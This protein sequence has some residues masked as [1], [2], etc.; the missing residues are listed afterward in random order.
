MAHEHI[1]QLYESRAVD[2]LST[3]V[4]EFL[5]G[6]TLQAHLAS[7][8]KRQMPQSE[9]T[10]MASQILAALAHMHS[11]QVIHRDIKPANI[12]RHCTEGRPA[13]WKLIDMGIAA[14]EEA[15]AELA[16][17]VKI[18]LRGGLTNAPARTVNNILT[19]SATVVGYNAFDFVR[20]KCAHGYRGSSC[21]EACPVCSCQGHDHCSNLDQMCCDVTYGCYPHY[22]GQNFYNRCERGMG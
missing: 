9:V 8:S 17:A 15:R 1:V 7:A 19:R 18:P 21:S 3:M 14:V 22:S 5:N 4:L 11:K 13:V 20:C 10:L 2:G 6:G 16:A 12:M